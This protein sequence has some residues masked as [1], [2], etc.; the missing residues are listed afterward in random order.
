MWEASTPIGPMLVTA[1]E[2]EPGPAVSTTVSGEKMQHASTSDL[3]FGPAALVSYIST[4]ITL[5]PGDLI[6]TGTPGGVG[7]ARTPERYL[8]PGDV[9]ETTIEGLGTLRNKVV[10]DASAGA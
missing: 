10:A 7:R 6:L 9:V 8:T 5:R 4:M 2:W 1:D 3:L